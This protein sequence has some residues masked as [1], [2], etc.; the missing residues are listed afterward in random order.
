MKFNP[1]PLMTACLLVSISSR[2]QEEVKYRLQLQE[3]AFIPTKNISTDQLGQFGKQLKRVGGKGLVIIQFETVP[4]SEQKKQLAQSGIELLDYIPNNA[5]TATLTNTADLVLLQRMNARAILEPT[6]RQKMQGKLAQGI[7]P[8]HAIKVQNA[9]DLWIS[10]PKSFSFEEVVSEFNKNNVEVIST[11]Y[12]NYRIIA[13]RISQQR[14]DEIAALPIIDFVQ[15][16][17]GEDVPLNLKSMASSRANVLVSPIGRNLNGDSVVV[18]V[19]D[20]SNPYRH[21]DFANRVINRNTASGG[22]HGI[23]VMGTVGGAG[24]VDERVYGYAPKSTIIAQGFSNV[25]INAPAY[26]QDYGMVITNNSY[27][28]IVNECDNFG[29]YDL[30]SRVMDQMAADYPSLQNVFASGNNGST[31]CTGYPAGFRNVLGG[32]QSAKNIITVGATN[33]LLG[34]ASFSSEGPVRDGRVKPEIMAQG[35][36][37]ISTWPT[38]IYSG[39]NGTS[40]AA[41]AV[42]GGLALLYQHY[43]R[44]H[45]GAN[46]KAGLMKA[47]LINGATDLGNPG[48]DYSFGYGLMNLLRSAVMMENNNYQNST[49]ATGNTINYNLVVPANIAQLRVLLYWNDKPAAVLANQTL[50]NDLDL[51]VIDPSTNTLLPF[52]L[53]TVPAN[54]ASN[55]ITGADHINNVEQVVINNP[56]AGTYTLRVKGTAV[57]DGPTQ[58]YFLVFDTIPVSTVLTYPVGGEKFFPNDSLYVSWESYGNPVNDFTIEYTNNNGSTWATIPGGTNVPAASRQ[59]K[60]YAPSGTA[61]DTS[62]QYKIRI[63]RNGTGMV[64]TSGSFTVLGTTTITL[65]PDAEQCEGYFKINWTPVI[66]AT[67]Y[68]VMILRGD[69]MVSVIIV[70]S[71]TLTYT[72]GG[73]SRDTTYWVTVRPRIN[74]SPGRRGGA[75][76]RVPNNGSCSGSISNNDVRIDSILSPGAAGRKFTLSELTNSMPVTIRIKNIDDVSTSSN[77]DVSYYIDGVLQ[78]TQ[79]IS[80]TIAGGGT[81]DHTFSTNADFSAIGSKTLQVIVKKAGDGNAVNDTMRKV[82]RQLDNAPITS[83]DLPWLDDL[84]SAPAQEIISNRMGL[85]GRDRYDLK[86]TTLFGRLRTFLNSGIAYSGSKA[87]TL[88]IDRFSAGGNIDSLLATFNLATFNAATNNLRLDFRYKNHGQSNHAANKFWI[89]G[90]ETDA[91]IQAYDLY[92]NQNNVDGSYKL[93]S[94]IDISDLL[95]ANGQNYST[96]F[97]VKWGQFGQYIAADNDG[98]NG[99]TIDDIRIYTVADDMQV[100]QI[101]EPVAASCNLGNAVQVKALVYNGANTTLN[102][103]PIVL[104]VNNTVVATEMITT[105]IP[106]KT[107]GVYTFGTTVDFS[108]VGSYTIT[109]YTQL[110]SDTYKENDTASAT[111]VNSTVINTFPYLQDFESGNGSWYASGLNSSWEYGTPNSILMNKAASGTKAWKTTSTGHYKDKEYSYLYSPCFDVSGMTNPTLSFM[112]ALDLEDCGSSLCDATWVEYSGDGVTW[113][114]LGSIGTGTNWYNKNYSGVHLWSQQS[115]TR[116]HV[117]TAALPTSANSRLRLRFVMYSD[118]VVQREGVGID[119]IHIYDNTYG[120]YTTAG[121]SPVV[122]QGTVNGSNWINFVE[123]GSN[124]LIASINP[125]GQDLGSTNVQSFIHS[126]A[127]RSYGDQYYHNRNITIKPTTNNLGGPATVRFYFLDSE[128]E[129]LIAA[130]G[131]GSCSKPDWVGELGVSKYSDP[132]DAIEDGDVTNSIGNYWSFI[133]PANAKKVPFDRGYYAEYSVTDFSEFWLND[134]WFNGLTP[135]PVELSSFTATKTPNRKDVLVSWKTATEIN[136]DRFEIEMAKGNDGLSQNQFVK[137][138][139]VVAVGNSVTEQ[140]YSFVDLELNKSGVRHYRLK[141]VD[142]DG[143][144]SYSLIRPVVF[145]DEVKWQVFPNPSP[146]IFNF[147]YQLSVGEKMEVR[148]FDATGK[149]VFRTTVTGSGFVQKLPIDL[150]AAVFSTGLYLLEASTGDRRETFRVIKD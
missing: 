2:A 46:P 35:Q 134:G 9:I 140:Q 26:V 51:E 15:P 53:D 64:S 106:A 12:K 132:N 42:S 86:T 109:V 150:G 105:P 96:S 91:W 101:Q 10:F 94:G 136:V 104:K 113:T 44:S 80:P 88:D 36:A 145:S 89:R 1:I 32:F 139:E 116:W 16:I 20:D 73:L 34:I 133:T 138:G 84:E 137:I 22:A 95:L 78:Q 87:L 149:S 11:V 79:T 77:L 56:A 30:Y 52:I 49:I 66:H 107:G 120:I 103:I 50:V 6:P 18:G 33:E 98:R 119:D 19:G 126:G 141:I 39:N 58:E 117:A 97:Q 4:T 69:E 75:V 8:P 118:P 7:F 54:V 23:H 144:F 124:K 100:L 148:V 21:I 31:N 81:S 24:I 41:P 72:I 60:W 47:L 13:I 99:Y 83:G 48:P 131:C 129:A 40:M 61:A 43:R 37:V 127:V 90:S 102:N 114:K 17:P 55:A 121:T 65:A 82:V 57:N 122:N 108:A 85:T 5:F 147:V 25:L 125:N 27:G 14:L 28:N 128:T 63:T 142:E 76:S 67:D 130:T 135:L 38:N 68:E 115:Y 3:G 45:A 71:N 143:T 70:P 123:S 112:L 29:V 59:M 93:A 110:A 92:A 74:G 146:A 62:N 111:I